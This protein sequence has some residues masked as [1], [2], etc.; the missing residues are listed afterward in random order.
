M[1]NKRRWDMK[2]ERE[3]ERGMD[4]SNTL[5]GKE[6]EKRTDDERSHPMLEEIS[7]LFYMTHWSKETEQNFG[8]ITSANGSLLFLASLGVQVLHPRETRYCL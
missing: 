3:R 2:I 4:V 6:R 8:Q 1:D 5:G 7:I